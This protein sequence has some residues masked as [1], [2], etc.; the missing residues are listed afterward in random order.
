[1][2]APQD[3]ESGEYT[4]LAEMR[5]A[6]LAG[7]VIEY[8][9]RRTSWLTWLHHAMSLATV[10]AI[11]AAAIQTNRSVLRCLGDFGLALAT[12]F[13]VVLPLHELLHAA[14]YRLA[15]ARDIRWDYS[16]RM[17][18]VWVI[19]H[20]FVARAGAFVFVALAPFVVINGMLLAGAIALPQVSVFLLFVLLWHLHGAIGDWS[21]LNFIWLHRRRGFWTYDDADKGTSYFFGR[22]AA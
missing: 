11:V 14:A 5:H 21:L 13:V 7:F 3:L 19:A 16:L 18:A 17:A 20:R 8:F 15:G 1:L 2:T 4:L 22:T 6:S 9:M 12:L 10:A